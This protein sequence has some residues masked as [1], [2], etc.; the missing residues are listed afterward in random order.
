MTTSKRILL[1][2]TLDTKGE[3]AAF[4]ARA[5]RSRGY[6]SASAATERRR[7]VAGNAF[8]CTGTSRWASRP[9]R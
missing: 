8:G 2:A 6:Q 5:I 1:L 7:E 4:V 9:R 3:E